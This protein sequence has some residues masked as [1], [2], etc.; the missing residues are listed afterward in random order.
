MTRGR[1]SPASLFM[2]LSDDLSNLRCLFTMNVPAASDVI[3]IPLL[4]IDEIS[5]VFCIRHVLNHLMVFLWNL[6]LFQHVTLF[7]V[8]SLS[9]LPE[10]AL[11]GRKVITHQR[12]E[13]FIDRHPLFGCCLLD[14]LLFPF[15]ECKQYRVIMFFPMLILVLRAIHA[16]IPFLIFFIIS[17][18]YIRHKGNSL[19]F[20]CYLCVTCVLPQKFYTFSCC[21]I[22]IRK[23]KK[24]PKHKRFGD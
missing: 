8:E 16:I 14:S 7:L 21:S 12:I 11:S 23:L 10:P 9:F 22:G 18:S 24:S 4:K 17:L 20:V 2:C 6:P 1:V 3:D 19:V 5:L 13:I 15:R